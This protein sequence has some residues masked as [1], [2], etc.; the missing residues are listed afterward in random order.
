ME[1]IYLRMIAAAARY[2]ETVK[3]FLRSELPHVWH[4][5]YVAADPTRRVNVGVITRGT[6]DYLYDDQ[7]TLVATGVVP[8]EPNL[9]SRVMAVIGTSAPDPRHRDD[10]R[11]RGWLGATDKT[12]GKAWDKGHFIAHSIG[13]AV[14]GSEL[15]VFVQ[16]RDLNR[17]WS[18]AGRRYRAMETYCATRPH[19]LCWSRPIYTDGSAMPLQIEFG[20]LKE[21]REL[22][23]ETF[24]NWW[25]ENEFYEWLHRDRPFRRVFAR[26]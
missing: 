16:R 10:Y 3:E 19:V 13:G 23:L 14:A 22:W 9:E 2:G 26:Q 7:D 4:E 15:N 25:A 5:H 1:Q 12:F 18:A 24:D 8:D 17:G 21:D 11:L 6:F 20:I